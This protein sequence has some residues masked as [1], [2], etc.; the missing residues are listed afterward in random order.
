MTRFRFILHPFG[1]GSLVGGAA[2]ALLGLTSGSELGGL[3][4]T[5]GVLVVIAAAYLLVG[6]RIHAALRARREARHASGHAAG[7]RTEPYGA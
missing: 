2:V 6:L 7:A 3:A 4:W 5:Y 1:W